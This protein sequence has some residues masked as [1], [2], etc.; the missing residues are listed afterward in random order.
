MIGL[1]RSDATEGMLFLNRRNDRR[2]KERTK[3]S[4]LVLTL[5]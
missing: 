3:L 4:A 1:T 2:Q 5:S